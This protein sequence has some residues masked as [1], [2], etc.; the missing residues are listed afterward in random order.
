MIRTYGAS[1]MDQII[2]KTQVFDT[3]LL[4]EDV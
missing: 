3:L 1:I 2:Y 4:S